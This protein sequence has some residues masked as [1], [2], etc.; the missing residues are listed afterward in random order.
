MLC[1]N[2]MSF[3]LLMWCML[4]LK[5]VVVMCLVCV[6]F[7]LGVLWIMVWFLILLIE[8]VRL[9]GVSWVMFV[10]FN[11]FLFEWMIMLLLI[12]GRFVWKWLKCMCLVL[13]G[14][15]IMLCI[16]NWLL[17]VGVFVCGFVNFNVCVVLLVVRLKVDGFCWISCS[18]LLIV[19]G[20]LLVWVKVLRF[21]RVIVVM[22]SS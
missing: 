17:L 18:V 5:C 2:M 19:V 6:V 12:M 1:V 7:M 20:W 10:C 8:L 11:C 22:G 4:E 9:I 15:M 16:W 13:L 3:V 14:L 21:V